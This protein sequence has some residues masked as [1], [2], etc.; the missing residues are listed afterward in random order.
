MHPS[1]SNEGL[2]TR[3]KLLG[4]MVS[5]VSA[6]A[7]L[8]L[9]APVAA[10]EAVSDGTAISDTTCWRRRLRIAEPPAAGVWSHRW[11]PRS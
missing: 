4:T 7:L 3:R 10:A 2:R 1:D 6:A 5:G 9:N 11:S 8:G